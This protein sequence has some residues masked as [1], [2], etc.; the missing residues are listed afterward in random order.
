MLEIEK[1][2]E[3]TFIAT[4][5][6]GS[7]GQTLLNIPKDVVSYLGIERGDKVEIQI[8]KTGLKSKRKLKPQI[9]S[10]GSI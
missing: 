4:A 3:T 5:F 10:D 7:S 6:G 8:R 1:K 9:K 2:S